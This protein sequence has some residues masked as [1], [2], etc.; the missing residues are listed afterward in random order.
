MRSDWIADI[1]TRMGKKS[2]IATVLCLINVILQLNG[3]D[4]QSP[5]IFKLDDAPIL[6]KQFVVKY[7]KTYGS[8]MEYQERYNNFVRT[9]RKI[10]VK[11]SHPSSVK[12]GPN[13]YADLT[14]QEWNNHLKDLVTKTNPARPRDP[15]LELARHF[16]SHPNLKFMFHSAKTYFK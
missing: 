4:F 13:E 9:L 1:V 5:V 10:N 6:F 11:N 3:Q 2:V 14:P 16:Q 8:E 15:E 7:N 12:V